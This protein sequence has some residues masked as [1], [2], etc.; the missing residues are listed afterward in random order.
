M[1]IQENW[2]GTKLKRTHLHVHISSQECRSKSQYKDS[3]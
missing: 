1:N 3:Q 2:E